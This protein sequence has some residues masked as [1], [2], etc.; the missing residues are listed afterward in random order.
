MIIF[1]LLYG[2]NKADLILNVLQIN[3]Y[4]GSVVVNFLDQ[5]EDIRVVDSRILVSNRSWYNELIRFL[6]VADLFF[7]C[8]NAIT[9]I[10]N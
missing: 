6:N 2:I 5:R 7:D 3:K 9:H 4:F 1:A 10:G 8:A